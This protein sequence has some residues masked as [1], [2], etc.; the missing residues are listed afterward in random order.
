MANDSHPGGVLQRISY[1]NVLFK[2]GI[3]RREL[4]LLRPS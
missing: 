3:T 2:E 1:A 4:A